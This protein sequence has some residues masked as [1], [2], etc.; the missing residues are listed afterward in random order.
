MI[1][2]LADGGGS[3]PNQAATPNVGPGRLRV[4][5]MR[6]GPVA[7]PDDTHPEHDVSP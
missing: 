3:S 1:R 6:C 7:P 2:R 4:A 5:A